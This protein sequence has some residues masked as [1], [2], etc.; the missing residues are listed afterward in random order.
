M[1]H[2]FIAVNT[3]HKGGNSASLVKEHYDCTLNISADIPAYLYKVHQSN[4]ENKI[5]GANIIVCQDT[6]LAQVTL[7]AYNKLN[8]DIITL[9]IS[10][11]PHYV[12]QQNIIYIGIEPE[13]TYNQENPENPDIIDFLNSKLITYFLLTKLNKLS[14]PK[15]ESFGQSIIKLCA[16]KDVHVILDLQIIDPINCPSVE[17]AKIQKRFISLEHLFIILN[18]KLNIKYL[19]IFGFDSSID[20][21]TNKFTKFTGNTCRD[22]IK[23]IFKIKDK[24]INI[25]TEDSRFLIFRPLDQRE[26][27][28][29]HE[30]EDIGWYIVRFMTLQERSDLISSLIDRTI[31]LSVLVSEI[32]D[33]PNQDSFLIDS[34]MDPDDEIDIL[35]TTTTMNE[36]NTKSYYTAQ[37]IDD[38]CLF[39][40][41][42]QDMMFE[43]VNL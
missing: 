2:H 4:I 13:L 9:Y 29:K 43:L 19:D 8:P 1:N 34:N 15:L 42:K 40:R 41:Q 35:V 37:H 11:N 30:K 7:S 36:Q 25:F 23:H 17:R 22:I 24:Q 27:R 33:K 16:N 32:L 3:P 10:N 14:K 31:V 21:P 39:P 18:S 6:R 26:K 5:N 20:N 28:D 12:Y 38:Y